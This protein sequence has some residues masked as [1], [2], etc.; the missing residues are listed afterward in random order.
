MKNNLNTIVDYS[1]TKDNIDWT[2]TIKEQLRSYAESKKEKLP[3]NKMT[4]NKLLNE[5]RVNAD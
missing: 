4:N 3:K 5:E 1:P 2:N